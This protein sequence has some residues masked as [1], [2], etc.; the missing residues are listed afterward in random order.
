TVDAEFAEA[1]TIPS[2]GE[3]SDWWFEDVPVEA[4]YYTPIK[5]AYDA[6]RMAG[7]NEDYFEPETDITRGMFASA[8]YRMEGLPETDAENKFEDVKTGSYY[9]TA[10]AWATE[11]EIVAG[12]D[13][14]HYGPDDAITREQLAAILWRYAKYKE[15]DVSADEDT[16]ILDF[17]DALEISEYA[18]PAIQWA[19]GE[20]IITGFE[21]TTLRPKE[22]ANRAQMAVIL[23]KIDAFFSKTE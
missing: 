3:T 8:V 17:T 20:S 19:V 18:V 13:D 21:D 12:Y 10:I 6:E 9:E 1:G 14:T 4:W 5:E 11:N 16:N 7:M 22:N 15:M 2:G 23:N